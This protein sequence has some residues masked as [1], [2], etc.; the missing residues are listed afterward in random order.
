QPDDA[1]AVVRGINGQAAGAHG[2]VRDVAV[3][4]EVGRRGGGA[5]LEPGGVGVG[6]AGLSAAGAAADVAVEGEAAGA[7]LDAHQVDDVGV[8][9]GGAVERD[10]AVNDVVAAVVVDEVAADDLAVV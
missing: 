7:G 4:V 10:G 2:A 9:A 6:A 1:A 8:G 5:E 3:E